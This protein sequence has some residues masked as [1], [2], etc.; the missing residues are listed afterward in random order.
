[1]SRSER[2]TSSFVTICSTA[3]STNT[4]GSIAWRGSESLVLRSPDNDV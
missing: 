2:I 4:Q 1:L 3:R